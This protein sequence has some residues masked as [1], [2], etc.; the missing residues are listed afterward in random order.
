[1]AGVGALAWYLARPL[2][3]SNELEP[4]WA[5]QCPGPVTMADARRLPYADASFDAIATSPTYGNRMADHHQATERCRACGGTGRTNGDRHGDVCAKCAG[6]G[7]RAHVRHTYRHYLG[8]PLT[9][10]NTGQMHWGPTYRDVHHA[11]WAECVRVVRPGGRLVVNVK[12]HYRTLTRGQLPVLQ[13]VVHW[14]AMT[15]VGLGLGCAARRRVPCPGQRHGA[16]GH[17]RVDHEW[18]LVFDK[19]GDAG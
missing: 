17:A 1:M 5:S 4:E 14:H 2:V 18:V 15:L 8:R 19:P 12:D 6:A 9:E 13:P 3:C 11:I 10:A 7:R 16:N